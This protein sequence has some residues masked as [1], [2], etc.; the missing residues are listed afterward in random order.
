[1]RDQ[2]NLLK[3][4]EVFR[5]QNITTDT[6]TN[7]VEVDLKGFHSATFFIQ[8]GTVTDGTYTPV[9]QE[10]DTSG[11]YSGSV[12]DADLIGTEAAA[13]VTTTGEVTKVG[14]IG[15]KRYVRLNIASTSTST[16][17]NVG[18]IAILGYASDTPVA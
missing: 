1:M 12:A 7:G 15:S 8:A 16:G 9:I 11:S 3:G 10:S 17:G 18:A 5:F 13:A 4:A 6:T 2:K 14:Y